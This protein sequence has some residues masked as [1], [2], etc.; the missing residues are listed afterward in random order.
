MKAAIVLQAG[1]TP[2]YGDFKEPPVSRGE[3]R[4]AVTAA[5]L[6]PV[7]RGRASGAH[8]S[9]PADFPFVAGIDGVGRLDD[10]RRVY[11]IL[12]R[13]PFGSMAETAV[14]PSSQCV[15]LADGLD[16]I[17][18][19]AIANPGLSSWAGLKE[20][21]RLAPGETVMVNGA[22]GTSGRLAVQIAKYLGAKKVIATGR[23]AAALQSLK[24]L[25]ADETIALAQNTDALDGS[26]KE[27]FAG[28][29]NIVLDYLW[30]NSAERLLIAGAKAGQEGLPIRFI[31]IGNASGA[32][33]TL[34][35]AA[36]RSAPIEL[37]GSGLGSVPL[38]RIVKAV[39]ELLQAAVNGRFEFT[40]KTV[41]LSEVERA[42]PGDACI[43]RIVFTIGENAG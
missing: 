35:A 34:P 18:A 25:G 31:Q 7:V 23:N 30:G 40:A 12:P 43:P 37:M 5:A 27:H 33:I 2:V 8:Y 22:T 6:S 19:A 42:W 26:F 16:H 14:V 20:R 29:I 13:A 3:H 28:G 17:T 32:N 9:S 4:I 21:A 38:H 15:I 1:R 24:A 10:G 36:V 11:F 41:P 39:E